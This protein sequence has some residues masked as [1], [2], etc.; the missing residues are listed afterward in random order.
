[1]PFPYEFHPK[2][3]LKYSF[4]PVCPS[5][6]LRLPFFFSVN[7]LPISFYRVILLPTCSTERYIYHFHYSKSAYANRC[8][9]HRVDVGTLG[10]KWLTV[11]D[12]AVDPDNG[13][14]YARPFDRRKGVW[15]NSESVTCAGKE[16]HYRYFCGDFMECAAYPMEK[17]LFLPN[18]TACP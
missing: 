7:G 8:L 3:K 11:V 15:W 10:E 6:F 5:G 16:H 12:F 17:L 4:S 9:V 13:K 18:K 1:M 14:G 2:R